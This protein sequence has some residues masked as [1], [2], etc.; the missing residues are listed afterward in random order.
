M[1]TRETGFERRRR[2]S[3]AAAAP[4]AMRFLRSRRS[5]RG[6]VRARAQNENAEIAPVDG[7][8]RRV[9]QD[10]AAHAA[11][12]EGLEARYGPR[13]PGRLE[14]QNWTRERRRSAGA[15]L[16]P[17]VFVPS[18]YVNLQTAFPWPPENVKSTP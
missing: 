4:P 10:V 5:L 2:V 6:A 8:G 16:R 13:I 18:W 17:L 9:A 7:D 12:G 3:D 11:A 15:L 1:P 14:K